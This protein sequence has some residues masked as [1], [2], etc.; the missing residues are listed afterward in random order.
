MLYYKLFKKSLST[1][2]ICHLNNFS[3]LEIFP[4]WDVK[5]CFIFLLTPWSNIPIAGYLSDFLCVA[6]KNNAVSNK[7]SH[8]LTLCVYA[9][10]SLELPV[11]RIAGSKVCTFSVLIMPTKL[12]FKK[13]FTKCMCSLRAGRVPAV[14]HPCHHLVIFRSV[15]LLVNIDWCFLR[16]SCFHSSQCVGTFFTFIPLS[17]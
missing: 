14:P 8:V 11:S 5:V 3:A 10:M 15:C 16:L 6:I 12:L 17:K 13:G 9:R 7:N 4:Q 2:V 1:T